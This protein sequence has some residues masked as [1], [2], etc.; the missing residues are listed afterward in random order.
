MYCLSHSVWKQ[1]TFLSI[2]DTDFLSNVLF[3]QSAKNDWYKFAFLFFSWKWH[4]PAGNL[5][6]HNKERLWNDLLGTHVMT[7]EMSVNWASDTV[8]SVL[9]NISVWKLNFETPNGECLCL[10]TFW[11]LCWGQRCF[12]MTLDVSVQIL[13]SGSCKLE[14]SFLHGLIS[15]T[16]E[17][18]FFIWMTQMF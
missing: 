5:G 9:T 12:S 15:T 2:S 17:V 3:C 14:N 4:N 6:K 7:V 8:S 16:T 11:I 18:G 1:S 13:P 10:M